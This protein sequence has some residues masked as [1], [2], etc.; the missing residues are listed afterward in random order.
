MKINELHQEIK[1]LK[2]YKGVD[3]LYS[4]NNNQYSFLT[5]MNTDNNNQNKQDYKKFISYTPKARKNK[6]PFEIN[7]ENNNE[8]LDG[9]DIFGDI[10]ISEVPKDN[11][12]MKPPSIKKN[13]DLIGQENNNTKNKSNDINALA[14]NEQ[15]L[16]FIQEYKDNLNKMD[17]Q[18][19]KLNSQIKRNDEL[20][21]EKKY[22]FDV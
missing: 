10:K 9:N 17:E 14:N 1:L 4:N 7:L 5:Q 2:E 13:G 3:F 15:D 12:S 16:K 21:I 18:L 8:N 6:I 19:K 20:T 22:N 11:N